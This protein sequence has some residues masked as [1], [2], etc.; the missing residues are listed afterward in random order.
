MS[1]IQRAFASVFLFLSFAYAQNSTDIDRNLTIQKCPS[2]S[3][4]C[5]DLSRGASE[6]VGRY[7]GHDEPGATVLIRTCRALETTFLTG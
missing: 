3:G 2:N 4:F 7:T 5:A 1:T 6:L